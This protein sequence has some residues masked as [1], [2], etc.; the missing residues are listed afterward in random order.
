MYLVVDILYNYYTG[1][2]FIVNLMQLV[3]QG[4]QNSLGFMVKLFL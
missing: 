2:E 1:G 4:R 3:N